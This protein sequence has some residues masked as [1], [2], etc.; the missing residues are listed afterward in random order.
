MVVRKKRTKKRMTPPFNTS[1]QAPGPGSPNC[2]KEERER[3]RRK[4]RERERERRHKGRSGKKSPK[5]IEQQPTHPQSD[6]V[7]TDNNPGRGREGI[8]DA[9]YRAGTGVQGPLRLLETA[10]FGGRVFVTLL[11]FIKNSLL[12]YLGVWGPPARLWWGPV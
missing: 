9:R 12:E 2:N 7:T 1:N 11:S 10:Y 4:M 5:V 6:R 3:E 8:S